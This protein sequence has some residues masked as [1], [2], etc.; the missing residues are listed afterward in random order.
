MLKVTYMGE[1]LKNIYPHATKWQVF[2]Y[3][4]A[5][6]MRKTLIVSMIVGAVYGSFH[7]GRATTE[8][9][10]LQAEDK[11]KAMFMS[12]VD[13]LK[14]EV[15]NQLMACESAGHTE[16]DGIIIFDSNAKASIGNFQF[17]KDTVIHY[18]K[19]LY[20]KTIT[21]KEAVL[22][23]LDQ[24]KARSLAIDVMFTTKNKAG[25]DWFNCANKLK[26]DERID[27]IKSIEQ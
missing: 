9:V 25:R 24:D 19:V 17:Q 6:F 21:P 10:F 23:A 16:D 4:F 15:A 26:L 22:I 8:P 7:I 3:K 13:K 1:P 14:E 11:S 2:K 20:G 5:L 27:I 18:Y 12:K